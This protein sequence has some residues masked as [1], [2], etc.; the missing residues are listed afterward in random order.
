MSQSPPVRD[1]PTPEVAVYTDG[2][3]DPNPGPGGWGA[4]LRWG[5]REWVLSGNDPDTTNN[6]MELQAAAAALALLEGLA[7]RCQV[8]VHTDSQ[9]LRRGITEWVAGWVRRDWR[10]STGQPVKNQDL[11]RVLHR[12]TETHDVSWHWLKG[13]AG[14]P[15]NER[16]DRLATEALRSLRRGP[17]APDAHHASEKDQPAVEICVKAS[18]RGAQGPGG[19]GAVLRLGEKTRTLSGREPSTTA[20]AMLIRGAT[21]ALRALKRPCEVTLYSDA[22]YLVQGASLWVKGWQARGWQTREG[23]PVANQD[24]W[25]ALLEAAH[26]HQVTWLL[27]QGDTVPDDLVR[28]GEVA[29][30]AS[31]LE[32]E[33]SLEQTGTG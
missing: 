21:E 15:L 23:K 8:R 4:I 13:H 24:A 2:G 3:C 16:A 32:R 22:K 29:T 12:M 18:C 19:W 5:D 26:S 20:N 6:R 17:G 1:G 9:Y 27:A 7:G 33:A 25:E 30:Q 28:A 11:W 10:T 14:H 31:G